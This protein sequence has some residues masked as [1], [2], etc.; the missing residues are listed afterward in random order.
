L[1]LLQLLQCVI[2]ADNDQCFVAAAKQVAT[3]TEQWWPSQESSRR[4]L[5]LADPKAAPLQKTTLSAHRPS[6]PE[7]CRHVQSSGSEGIGTRSCSRSSR[8][9]SRTSSRVRPLRIVVM[10][11]QSCCFATQARIAGV[12]EDPVDTE[13]LNVPDYFEIVKNPMCLLV[14]GALHG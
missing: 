7:A 2:T 3:N 10:R 8:P 13:K 11:L 14:S 1:L 6:K 9:S 5:L 12:F 4:M